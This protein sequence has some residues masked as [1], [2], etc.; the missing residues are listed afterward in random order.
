MGS[1]SDKEY[2][3]KYREP[4]PYWPDKGNSQM[5]CKTWVVLLVAVCVALRFKR[6]SST[7]VGGSL[8]I[9]QEPPDVIEWNG[10][11]AIAKHDNKCGYLFALHKAQHFCGSRAEKKKVIMPIVL[12]PFQ[13]LWY[14][15]FHS[16]PP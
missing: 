13:I 9:V 10:T 15:M 6:V 8:G 4:G 3:Y 1:K 5:T 12:R 11:E 16:A 7:A 14:L 2:A